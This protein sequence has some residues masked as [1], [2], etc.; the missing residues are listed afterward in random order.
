MRKA[1]DPMTELAITAL[2]IRKLED[3]LPY[4]VMQAR[5]AGESWLAIGVALGITAQ[6]AQQR[7]GKLTPALF[8]R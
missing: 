5:D 3:R 4:L 7:W 8:R 6:G 1:D 2:E